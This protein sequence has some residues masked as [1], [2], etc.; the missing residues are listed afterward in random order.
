MNTRN[1]KITHH[2]GEGPCPHCG[3]PL[4]VGDTAHELDDGEAAGF[5]SVACAG[6]ARDD[7]ARDLDPPP[8]GWPISFTDADLMDVADDYDAATR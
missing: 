2:T 8:V 1:Y 5:C 3:C 4:Y 7:V 6:L